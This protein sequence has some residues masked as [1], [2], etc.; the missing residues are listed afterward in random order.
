MQ[1]AFKYLDQ[2]NSGLTTFFDLR[3]TFETI[4]L[5]LKDRYV[6]FL[7]YYMKSFNNNNSGLEDLKYENLFKIIQDSEDDINNESS[8]LDED[9][10]KSRINF[11]IFD[12]KQ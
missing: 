4:N 6:E 8:E 11:N 2:E 1:K 12:S 5:T 9:D 7:I 10:L 3:T